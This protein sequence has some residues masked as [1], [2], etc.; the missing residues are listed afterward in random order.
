M[1]TNYIEYH[2]RLQQER[3]EQGK[4]FAEEYPEL[5]S[6]AY[7]AFQDEEHLCG[8]EDQPELHVNE[9]AHATSVAQTIFNVVCLPS[10]WHTQ[11]KS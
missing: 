11:D 10:T 9:A 7:Q 4:L 3:P 1:R 8:V 5:L 2:L 6:P